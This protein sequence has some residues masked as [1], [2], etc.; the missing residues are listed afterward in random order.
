[1]HQDAV[2]HTD[3]RSGTC[4]LKRTQPNSAERALDYAKET[5]A[6]VCRDEVGI[7]KLVISK[8]YTKGRE[9]YKN[10]QIHIELAERMKER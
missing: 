8:G 9:D 4:L 2:G 1:M 7:E 10:K 3:G 6:A 5:I